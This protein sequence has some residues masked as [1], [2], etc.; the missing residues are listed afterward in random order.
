MPDL[1]IDFP[2]ARRDEVI[3]YVTDRYGSDKVAQI[4]TFGT[5]KGKAAIKAVARTM[6]LPLSL[7]E[8]L[9]KLYPNPHAGKE[10]KLI[11]AYQRVPD[12]QSARRSTRPESKVLEWAEKIEGRVASYGIHASG[13]VIAN[14]PLNITLP[15]ARGKRGEVVTQW[16]MN[17]VED[18]GLIKFDFLGLKNLDV[19][20]L[21]MDFIKERHSVDIDIYN[22]PLD[23]EKVYA[24]KKTGS[25]SNVESH[26]LLCI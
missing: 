16:D 24:N 2:K 22:L 14:E 17:N 3:S 9:S 19:I 21:A 10:Y 23:D 18:V 7:G 13:V 6:G 26:Y 4:G 25:S 1:D 5:F 11:E 20:Q 8:R 12:L 15:L